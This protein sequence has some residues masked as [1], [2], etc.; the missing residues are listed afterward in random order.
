M[1]DF[2]A[3]E[4]IVC[5]TDFVFDAGFDIT[6]VFLRTEAK[7]RGF[8]QNCDTCVTQMLKVTWRASKS[9]MKV[10]HIDIVFALYYYYSFF[11]FYSFLT[12]GFYY[13]SD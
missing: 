13:E 9:S 5:S 8:V 11:F 6:L 4:G 7:S 12:I 2:A 3:T 10:Y 1:G